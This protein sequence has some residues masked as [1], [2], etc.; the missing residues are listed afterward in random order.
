M[1][2]ITPHLASECL[3]DLNYN[4]I[5]NWPKVNNDYLKPESFNI[6]VQINGKKKALIKTEN[7][8]LEKDLIEKVIKMSEIKKIIVG[9]NLIKHIYVKNKLINLILK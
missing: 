2:P 5:N 7:E 4:K 8:I 1:L 9:K 6:V 3:D